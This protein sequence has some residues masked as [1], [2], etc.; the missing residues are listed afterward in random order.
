[1]PSKS[2]NLLVY[3]KL[4]SH[5]SKMIS[6]KEGLLLEGGLYCFELC[7]PEGYYWGQASIGER[8]SIG[9]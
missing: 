1:M 2:S 4:T 6:L 5:F 8:A 3:C 7:H 9:G